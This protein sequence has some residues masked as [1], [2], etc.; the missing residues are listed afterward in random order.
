MALKKLPNLSE[1]I[2]DHITEKIIRLEVR[3]GERIMET[4][5]AQELD[6]SRSPIREALRIL[7]KNRLVELIPRRGA[8][9]TELSKTQI[10]HLCD[11]LLTL[12][13]LVA[14]Q[15][16]D[17]GSDNELNMVNESAQKGLNC[18]ERSDIDG[19]Y[20]ALF[21]FAVAT[22]KASHNPLLEQMV[23]ELL[24]SVKRII[25]ASFSTRNVALEKNAA[26]LIK[27]N[28]YL[29]KRNAKM[30]EKTVIDYIERAKAFAVGNDIFPAA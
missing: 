22:L 9:V 23:Q 24:P 27:G 18:A 12:L 30:A 25:Y 3:P 4:T 13:C 19:Y 21:E 26:V 6:V 8:R 7:Q 28:K 10:S 29:Q 2:A 20:A 17:N 1:Q 14:R 15:C 16:V 11:V 5:I